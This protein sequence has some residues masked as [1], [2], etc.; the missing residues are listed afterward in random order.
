MSPRGAHGS[1][2]YVEEAL[3]M[4][5]RAGSSYGVNLREIARALGCAH[6]NAYN[7]FDDLDDLL[8]HALVRAIEKQYEHSERAV[9]RAGR[10]PQRR[11]GAL[12]DSQIEFALA[13]PGWY[14]FIWLEPLRREPLPRA[15]SVMAQAGEGL[16]QL[17]DEAS[18]RSLSAR[19]ARQ[20][21]EDLHT[22]L[23]G[24]LVKAVTGRVRSA[25]PADIRR[26]IATGAR[27]VCRELIQMDRRH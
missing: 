6:T 1:D 12:I 9:T 17:V 8:A 25:A 10:A 26:D 14:S 20:I 15:L 19:R 16:M 27:R 5:D 21:A 18:D 2:R 7:Y 24:A 4:I 23:H 13:H 11:L 3:A 22:W